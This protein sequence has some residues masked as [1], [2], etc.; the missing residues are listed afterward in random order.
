MTG[1]HGFLRLEV[2]AGTR[3]QAGSPYESI[4]IDRPPLGDLGAT[5]SVILSAAG[6]DIDLILPCSNGRQL[7]DAAIGI[8][9]GSG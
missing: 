9:S 7:G 5:W 4:D 1:G 2:A 3:N 8:T 6:S